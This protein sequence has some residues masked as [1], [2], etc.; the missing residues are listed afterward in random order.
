MNVFIWH[1]KQSEESAALLAQALSPGNNPIPSGTVP[2]RGYKGIVINYGASPKPEYR[3]QERDVIKY[4]NDVNACLELKEL[5]AVSGLV[6][7]AGRGRDLSLSSLKV[8]PLAFD[9]DG[10]P[11]HRS[12]TYLKSIFHTSKFITCSSTGT[13]ARVISSQEDLD[14][15][16][17]DGAAVAVDIDYLRRHS[18]KKRYRVFY[19]KDKGFLSGVMSYSRGDVGDLGGLDVNPLFREELLRLVDKGLVEVTNYRWREENNA[20]LFSKIKILT[21]QVVEKLS[22]KAD[23]FCLELTTDD[24]RSFKL[25]NVLFSPSL[26]NSLTEEGLKEFLLCLDTWVKANS[27]SPKELLLRL[28]ENADEEEANAM[29]CHLKR[30]KEG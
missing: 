20:G 23:F 16:R 2:P 6:E 7:E 18:R 15:A 19:S 11:L 13:D 17:D 25:V 30:V 12:Y 28:I 1:S 26:R 4:F 14:G 27:V 24:D 5:S 22:E 3:W 21:R 29:L 9:A 8:V 10:E